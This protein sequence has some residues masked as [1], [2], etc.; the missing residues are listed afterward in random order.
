M[1]TATTART[2]STTTTPN[3]QQ[4]WFT[5]DADN[6]VVIAEGQLVNGAI[7]LSAGGVGI[8]PSYENSYD[9]AGHVVSVESL[10]GTSGT[11]LMAQRF[12]YDLR[13]ERTATWY[14]L[15]LTAGQTDN[16]IQSTQ[17]YDLARHLQGTVQYFA[18][19]GRD[20]LLAGAGIQRRRG[21][22]DPVAHRRHR[23]RQRVHRLERQHHGQPRCDGAAALRVCRGPSSRQGRAESARPELHLLQPIEN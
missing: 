5:Y 2:T 12:S 19:T 20:H 4:E 9:A 11:D 3:I 16:G 17:S 10:G 21:W 15:D 13:G 8:T 14:A 18:A 22:A 7:A 6:R 23:Q 1:P